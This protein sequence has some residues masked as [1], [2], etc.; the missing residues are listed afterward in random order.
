M[1][2]PVTPVELIVKVAPVHNG[3]GDALIP[4]PIV[5]TAFTDT[6]PVADTALVHPVPGY[7]TVKLYIPVA[8]VTEAENTGEVAA[9]L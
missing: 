8:A 4:P 3:F 9:E 1:P 7:V 5:G 6:M 2:E